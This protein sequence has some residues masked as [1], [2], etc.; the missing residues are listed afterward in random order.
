MDLSSPL[1]VKSMA[2]KVS[3]SLLTVT[4]ALPTYLDINPYD[5]ISIDISAPI[6]FNIGTKTCSIV[7]IGG[8][9]G[10][11]VPPR[12]DRVQLFTKLNNKQGM[13]I[14]M[15]RAVAPGV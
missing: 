11:K 5:L 9:K 12:I 13:S 6:Y 15:M 2:F 3:F 10:T 8:E 14:C 7:N 1:F 4:Q